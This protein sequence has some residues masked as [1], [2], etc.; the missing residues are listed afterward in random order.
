MA[1]NLNID[2]NFLFSLSAFESGWF[3]L[4]NQELNN[5]FGLTQAEGNNIKFSSISSAAS[6]WENQYGQSVQGAK[7]MKSFIAAIRKDGYNS[8]NPIYDKRL[9]ATY[10][11]MD[12]HYKDCT[13]EL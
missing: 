8:I 12:Q 13:C 4:H 7:D 6:Y 5:P 2:P 11:N 10:K 1:K 9:L 3:N